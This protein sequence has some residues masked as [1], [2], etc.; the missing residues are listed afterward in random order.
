MIQDD[1]LVEEENPILN[2]L[3]SNENQENESNDILNHI[4]NATVLIVE[5]EPK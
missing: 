5:I 3:I 1:P 2:E 4:E